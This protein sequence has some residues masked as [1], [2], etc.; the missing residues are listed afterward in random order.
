MGMDDAQVS[1]AAPATDAAP[2]GAVGW[3]RPLGRDLGALLVLLGLIAAFQAWGLCGL[4]AAQDGPNNPEHIRILLAWGRCAFQ[5][6]LFAFPLGT[7]ALI[8]AVARAR[9]WLAV[10][11]LL[12]L[13]CEGFG[14]LDWTIHSALN[15]GDQDVSGD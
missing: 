3:P 14:V 12:V 10:T 11:L 8:L 7:V 4:I 9:G 15:P 6:S 2:G 1:E 13:V 5:P